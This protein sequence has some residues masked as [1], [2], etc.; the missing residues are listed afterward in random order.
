VIGM[1]VRRYGWTAREAVLAAT[2]NA[3]WVIGLHERLGSL[4]I[5]KSADL[6]LLD[7]PIEHVPYRLG[8]NP[9]LAAF[10]AG[11][12]LYVRADTAARFDV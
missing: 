6:L 10:R 3:S 5:G 9:V 7:A 12:L 1:A 11:E 8:H 2:H 4:E